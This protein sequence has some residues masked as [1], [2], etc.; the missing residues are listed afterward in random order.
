MHTHI[1]LELCGRLSSFDDIGRFALMID[2]D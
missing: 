2:D 1:M